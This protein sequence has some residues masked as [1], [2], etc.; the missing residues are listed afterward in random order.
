MW[1]YAGTEIEAKVSNRDTP[2]QAMGRDQ[3]NG[4][5]DR[6]GHMSAR[7]SCSP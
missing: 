4:I 5:R 6:G 1:I 3:A 2:P 7:P